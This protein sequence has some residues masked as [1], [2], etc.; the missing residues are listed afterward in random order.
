[1]FNINTRS[2]TFNLVAINV[3]VFLATMRS[4]TFTDYLSLH[5]LF[6]THHFDQGVGF[7]PFQIITHMFMHGSI[8]HIFF[9]MWGLYMFGNILEH[10][11]GPRRFLAFYFI[12]G[13]G[14]VVLHMGV[15]I[16]MMIKM[17]GTAD[18]SIA[19]LNANP[20]AVALYVSQTL[21]ASGA[22][23]GVAT[24]FA[25]LFPNTE[26]MIIPIPIP[27]KAKYLMPV[28]ILIELSLGLAQHQGDNVAHFAHL[29][30]ALFGYL[31]VKYWNRD[32]TH[33]Y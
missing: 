12:T 15:Q 7:Q 25:T 26:L 22:I 4:A 6:N 30:G 33:F 20:D 29:G 31:L 11:W 9:N 19:M 2:V 5:Y 8:G 18:P 13:L 23:F 28:Y 32:N 24:A 10:V 16:F 27:V 3:I 17:T 21:G 14:A 1:M